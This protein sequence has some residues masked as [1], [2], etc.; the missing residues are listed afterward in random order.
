MFVVSLRSLSSA[1]GN[2]SSLAKPLLH[3]PTPQPA[4]GVLIATGT[5]KLLSRAGEYDA[6]CRQVNFAAAAAAGYFTPAARA[7]GDA[8]PRAMAATTESLKETDENELLIFSTEEKGIYA[9]EQPR[10]GYHCEMALTTGLPAGLL[11][12]LPA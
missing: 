9:N 8:P 12:G 10:K 2:E 3:A 1:L 4:Q 6:K 7:R 5:R 11:M